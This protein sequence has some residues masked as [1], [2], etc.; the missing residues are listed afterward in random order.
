MILSKS[1]KLRSLSEV[2]HNYHLFNVKTHVLLATVCPLY[3]L[4]HNEL[5]LYQFHTTVPEFIL[6]QEVN[7]MHIKCE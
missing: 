2:N 6:S 5:A 7:S 3:I 1:G 4:C